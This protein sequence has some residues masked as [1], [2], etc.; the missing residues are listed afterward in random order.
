MMNALVM[1]A[2]VS[3][4]AT[5]IGVLDLLAERKRRHGSNQST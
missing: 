2:G 1:F 4:F 3:L 5:V